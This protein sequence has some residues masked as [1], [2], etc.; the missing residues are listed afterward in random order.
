MIRRDTIRFFA[1]SLLLFAGLAF[2]LMLPL[3]KRTLTITLDTNWI[4]QRFLP[5]AI[6]RIAPAIAR[7]DA[8]ARR[9]FLDTI[10][11][12]V[13]GAAA[14][15][16]TRSQAASAWTTGRMILMVVLILGVY[17]LLTLA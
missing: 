12:L 4:Y 16:G 3:M 6:H 10:Y 13:D 1:L 17:V 8:R 15:Y 2:F 11:R 5:R 14:R 9:F 7:A